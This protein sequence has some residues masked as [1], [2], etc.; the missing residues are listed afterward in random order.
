LNAERR[1]RSLEQFRSGNAGQYYALADG[2]GWD[3]CDEFNPLQFTVYRPKNTIAELRAELHIQSRQPRIRVEN[4]TASQ[5]NDDFSRRTASS[6]TLSYTSL[7]RDVWNEVSTHT[8]QSEC[9]ELR[10]SVT[11]Y[12][13]GQ[14]PSIKIRLR[15]KDS[16]YT[17][18]R[19]MPVT[20]DKDETR[21][22]DL[23]IPNNIKDDDIA[24]EVYPSRD[25]DSVTLL[26]FVVY[27]EIGQHTH[28][29]EL[30]SG[31]AKGSGTLNTLRAD[32]NNTEITD[33]KFD[34]PEPVDISL[35]ITN[36]LKD[37]PNTV[38]V[39]PDLL[40]GGALDLRAEVELE[41]LKN[42]T[43]PQ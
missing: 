33:P 2:E 19:E 18:V 30:E 43:E 34:P 32:I 37:G 7:T 10:V 11:L 36:E 23:F 31:V 25:I 42:A 3:V 8:G 21:H 9:S 6:D 35:D 14:L 16:G 20:L 13:N 22:R 15:N 1:K 40:G 38:T 4:I 28:Q 12:A 39:T 5:T 24:L 41:G 26:A 27:E 17:Q 29:I